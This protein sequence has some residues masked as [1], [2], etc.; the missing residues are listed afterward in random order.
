MGRRIGWLSLTVVVIAIG[1][2][3]WIYS[4][5]APWRTMRKFVRAVESE[6]AETIVAL[7]HPDEIKHCGLTVESVKA[8]L[9][10]T[11]G[12]WRP[13]KAVRIVKDGFFDADLGWHQWY[14]VWG[15]AQTNKPIAFNKVVKAFP[16][17]GIQSPQLFSE[18]YVC[19]T[20]KGWRV[21]V[22]AFLINLVLCVYGRPNAYSVLYSAG[23]RGYITYMTEPGQFEPLPTPASK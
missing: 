12:K 17:L 18:L 11:L 5:T 14:V 8:I 16:L 15:D 4:A 20:D 13:F 22:T 7:A 10:A 3:Y 6:D 2:G 19:P 1:I 9:N 23:I 21:N